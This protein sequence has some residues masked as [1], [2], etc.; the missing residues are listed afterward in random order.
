MPEIVRLK[1][2]TAKELQEI[3]EIFFASSTRKEF[4]DETER[5]DFFEKY[6]GYYL[7]H[8]SE[9]FWVAKEGRILG[10]MAGAP[11]TTDEGLFALQPHLKTFESFYEKYPAH[12]HVNLHADARGMGLGSELYHALEKDFQRMKIKGLHVMTAPDSR[13]KSFY[14]RLG[15]HFEVVLDYKGSPILLM[16]KSL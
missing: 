8:F 2:P 10:Y 7:K 12:L 6:V 3:R 14:E 9:F 16:G 15:L 13:N 4:Q 11:D 1:N 5:E